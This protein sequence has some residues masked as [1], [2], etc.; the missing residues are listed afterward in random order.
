MHIAFSQDSP[1]EPLSL[2]ALPMLFTDRHRRQLE[3]L[4]FTRV[5]GVIPQVNADAVLAALHEVSA[6]DY[7]D[8]QTWYVLP[9]DYAGII[10]SH[11]H[12]SQWDIR[13]HEPLYAVFSALWRTRALWVSMDR[14]G[15]VP[16]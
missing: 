14:I 5:E 12:Q 4:G 6:V 10:P 2:T 11:H 7:Q 16:P 3:Q 8:P 9:A 15:F 13:Q 1:P